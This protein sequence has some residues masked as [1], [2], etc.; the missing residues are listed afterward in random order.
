M[1]D[2]AYIVRSG[3]TLVA[4]ARRNGFADWREIYNAPQNADFR[5]R[6]PDPNRIFPGDQL[7]LP[8]R[9]VPDVPVPPAPPVPLPQ[10][11]QPTSASPNVRLTL[12]VR[13]DDAI[14]ARFDP[15][16]GPVGRGGAI[17]VK[18]N[19][20]QF[21]LVAKVELLDPGVFLCGI[22]QTM[23]LCDVHANYRSKE[24][25]P[26]E[27]VFRNDVPS[28]PMRDHKQPLIQ[29]N[30]DWANGN[31]KVLGSSGGIDLPAGLAAAVNPITL[32]HGDDPGGIFP[33]SPKDHNEQVIRQI[34]MKH[35]FVTWI[36]LR[37][38]IS[39]PSSESSYSFLQFESWTIRREI[40]VQWISGRPIPSVVKSE[41]RR[42]VHGTGVGQKKPVLKPP[43]AGPSHVPQ[44]D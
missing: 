34:I 21:S 24:Q 41:V 17:R 42:G 20:R 39:D 25:G 43:D 3:D 40:A 11:P 18:H 36:A 31:F 15:T 5:R 35:D 22:L 30:T 37:A 2:G 27:A 33:L 7:I 6:R 16:A 1:A 26:I 13:T 44:F 28:L 4:I 32:S 29:P 14:T 23:F 12:D 9:G 19:A 38:P 8:G 10:P